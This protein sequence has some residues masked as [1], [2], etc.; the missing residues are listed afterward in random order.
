MVAAL[1]LIWWSR[2]SGFGAVVQSGTR[3]PRCTSQCHPVYYMPHNKVHSLSLHHYFI[4][5]WI[6]IEKKSKQLQKHNGQ[7][8]VHVYTVKYL[9]LEYLPHSLRITSISPTSLMKIR[10]KFKLEK[11]HVVWLMCMSFTRG[12]IIFNGNTGEQHRANFWQE[13]CLTCIQL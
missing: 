4:I 13:K 10:R 12:N 11:Y 7:K 5:K 3:W 1:P 2:V 8:Y 9:H 6:F